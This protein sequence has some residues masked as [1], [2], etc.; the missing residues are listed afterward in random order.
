[1]NTKYFLVVLIVATLSACSD[2]TP[3]QIDVK[4]DIDTGP[5]PPYFGKTRQFYENNSGPY[6]EMW[7]WCK[8]HPHSTL[9]DDVSKECGTVQNVQAHG[10]P[11]SRRT[12]LRTLNNNVQLPSI[13]DAPNKST[14]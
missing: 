1:M 14:N 11:L 5:R 12:K 6:D 10:G 4:V 13:P 2:E 8:A 7:T 9:S 3:T